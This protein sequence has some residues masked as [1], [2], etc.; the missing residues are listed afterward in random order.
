MIYT[1]D[2]VETI[3]NWGLKDHLITKNWV[4]M[5]LERM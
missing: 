3:L 2:K 1:I 4:E 5:M